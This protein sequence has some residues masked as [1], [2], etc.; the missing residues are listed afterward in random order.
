MSTDEQFPR[1]VLQ[2]CAP[3]LL[4]ALHFAVVYVMVGTVPALDGETHGCFRFPLR[5]AV[6]TWTLIALGG[7]AFLTWRTLQGGSSLNG[8]ERRFVLIAAAGNAAIAT[9]AMLWA[10]IAVLLT[11]P[12][13]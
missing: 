12:C 9:T 2:A 8:R 6:G 10:A 3:L 13:A 7:V 5:V 4:W 1:R 11:L